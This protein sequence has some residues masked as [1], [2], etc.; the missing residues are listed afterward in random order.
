MRVYILYARIIY[1]I[2]RTWN[3]RKMLEISKISRSIMVVI[4]TAF[5]CFVSY[6]AVSEKGLGQISL[7]KI[8]IYL[9]IVVF[10]VC[11]YQVIKRRLRGKTDNQTLRRMYRFGY[12]AVI[13]VVSR[14]L[15]IFFLKDNIVLTTEFSG[16][17]GRILNLVIS[18][19]SESK[20]SAIILNTIIAYINSV[21]IKKIMLNIF[22][23]DAV[24][25]MSSIIYILSP[26]SLMK[27]CVFDASAF[28]TLFILLGMYL[29]YKIYD[30]ISEYGLKS[31]KYIWLSCVL[32]VI[33]I[34]D[35]LFGENAFIWPV[36]CMFLMFLP[37]YVDKVSFNVKGKSVNLNKGI[38]TFVLVTLLSFTAWGML[39]IFDLSVYTFGSVQDMF[40]TT[41]KL[42]ILSGMVVVIFETLAVAL[43][44]R[45]NFKVTFVKTA[46]VLFGLLAIYYMH[47]L[48]VFDTLFSMAFIL[49][50]GNMYYNREEKIKLLKSGN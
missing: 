15:V 35:I 38:I 7:T 21:I 13:L 49:S 24:A 10:C 1:G 22:E 18:L 30:E 33:V 43:N 40:M 12:L 32:A 42:Y 39:E 5:V 31:K 50:I 4:Y 41:N 20:Y 48:L 16:L 46:V 45:N 3:V 29:M 36:L 11:F 17:S 8:A 47:S 9:V 26:L 25:T 37:D 23:N 2:I 44:R 27:C 14:I 6:L 19:T 28:N 34:F